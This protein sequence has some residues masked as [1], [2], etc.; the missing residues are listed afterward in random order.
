MVFL[1]GGERLWY[2]VGEEQIGTKFF[3]FPLIVGTLSWWPGDI[4]A[5]QET[6]WGYLTVEWKLKAL[7]ED[8]PSEGLLEVWCVRSCKMGLWKNNNY[9]LI[10]LLAKRSP[11]VASTVILYYSHVKCF[12]RREEEADCQQHFS[13][14]FLCVWRFALASKFLAFLMSVVFT[15]FV[16]ATW[17]CLCVQ[18]TKPGFP[19]LCLKCPTLPLSWPASANPLLPP[20]AGSLWM[21]GP[22]VPL[23]E[24]TLNWKH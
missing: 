11:A 12:L 5:W 9:G 22:L 13:D 1:A 8:T 7:S 2:L 10:V 17:V 19:L 18:G 3:I 15:N 23:C 14:L 4:K 6:L 20:P 24:P 21:A 16:Y